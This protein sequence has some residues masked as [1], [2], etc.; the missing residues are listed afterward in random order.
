MATLLIIDDERDIC[1]IL[2]D[3]FQEQKGYAILKADNGQDGVELVK[4][5]HPDVILLDVKLQAGMDGVEVLQ[6]IK[7]HHPKAKIV[8]ITGFVEEVMERKIKE[9]GVDAYIEKP[10][11]PPQIINA[12]KDVLQKKWSEEGGES[13]NRACD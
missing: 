6:E 10:F 5:H 2:E 12:V 9:L 4:K 3:V 7:R 13:K 1:D 8:M 11:T